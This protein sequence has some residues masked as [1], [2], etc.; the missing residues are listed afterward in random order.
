MTNCVHEHTEECDRE[1]S[2]EPDVCSHQC[3]EETGCIGKELDCKHKHDEVCGYVPTTEGTPCTY[4]CEICNPPVTEEPKCIC[5]TKCTEGKN[6]ADCPVCGEEGD[7]SACIGAEKAEE[8]KC[9]CETKCTEEEGNK[10]CPVCGESGKIDG[11]VG[12]AMMLTFK[13]ARAITPT[14]PEGVGTKDNPYQIKTKEELYW[15]AELVNG[16]LTDDNGNPIPADTDA[17]AVLTKN[18]TINENVLNTDGSLNS[19]TFEPWTL[20]GNETDPY[21]GTFDGNGH[22]ISG[23]YLDIVE[24]S[25]KYLYAGLFGYSTGTI[26]N[27]NIDDTY[28]SVVVQNNEYY[29]YLYV[30]G[31]CGYSNGAIVNCDNDGTVTAE[32][33]GEVNVGGICGKSDG[34]ITDC[35]NLGDING[36]SVEEC[37]YGGGISGSNAGKITNCSSQGNIKAVGITEAY[38]GGVCG[39]NY[40][41]KEITNCS[42]QGDI[43]AESN[44][45]AYA[46]GICGYNTAPWGDETVIPIITSCIS[47]G[48]ITASGTGECYCGGVSGYNH[49]NG[50]IQ[51]CYFMKIDGLDG[52]G[53]NDGSETQGIEPKQAESFSSGEVAWL[54]NHEQEPHQWVQKLGS[55]KMPRPIMAEEDAQDD[56]VQVTAEFPNEVKE[57]ELYYANVDCSLLDYPGK[58]NGTYYVFFQEPSFT[59]PLDIHTEAYHQDRTIYAKKGIAVTKIVLDR[60]NESLYIGE[61]VKLLANVTPSDASNL[62]LHWSSSDSTVAEVDQEGNVKA[63]KPGTA[64]ITV[65]ASDGQGA[66]A[67]CQVDVKQQVTGIALNKSELSLYIGKEETLTATIEPNTAHDPSLT[68]SSS[69]DTVATVDENGNV[70]ALK[71]GTAIITA[72]A[73]DGQGAKAQCTVTIR[74]KSSSGGGSPS[75]YYITFDTNGGE[76]MEKLMKLEQTDI[77]MDEYIPE[78][79]GY[80]FVGW[81]RDADLEE[82]VEDL[83]LT[84]DMTLYAKWEKVEEEETKEEMEETEET[85]KETF[86]DVSENDWYFD[87]VNYVVEKGIMSGMGDGTFHPNLPFT[88][89][90]LAVVLYHMEGQPES[91]GESGFTDVKS[92]MWYTDTILWAKENGIVAG[93]DN[94]TYGVG[95]TITREQFAAIL[96][97]YASLKGYDITQGGM[98]AREFLDYEQISDY[99]KPAVSWAVNAG[100]ISG[101][102]DGTLVPQG[103][104][105]RAEAATMLMHFYGAIVES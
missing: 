96:Y 33:T 95:D 86:S 17:C 50:I 30:G 103:K 38:A 58:E 90:M 41:E 19:G 88:R 46:G 64:I 7:I 105:T 20:M 42:S 13:G 12:A 4:V 6:N 14:S 26:Q 75:Y 91:H 8:Q 28:I 34:T 31:I 100:I 92:G 66:K 16:T 82:R 60:E 21:T 76:E 11:C 102:G 94:G 15:F 87:S 9:I 61:T 63:L 39:E 24:S 83:K 5:Q 72:E 67:Q 93:Y 77:D 81:Y 85:T 98:A 68:W 3:S 22:T 56:V 47:N 101:M 73:A 49:K 51:D 25:E 89:E 23:L 54:L 84:R 71:V 2:E 18:I 74:K 43:M 35:T 104:T 10:N 53:K 55:E 99:A 36:K 57:T 97:R 1:G 80:V 59:T 65:E 79:E 37:I 48:N 45:K 32:A 40:G 29:D 44:E 78:K 27:V 62:A 52:I 70:K 69:D